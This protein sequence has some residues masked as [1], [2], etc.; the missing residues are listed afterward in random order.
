LNRLW[1]KALPAG[2]PLAEKDRH[3]RD[4]LSHPAIARMSERERADL[5]FCPARVQP[6]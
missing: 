2:R 1:T 5:P 4:P 3:F 6:E